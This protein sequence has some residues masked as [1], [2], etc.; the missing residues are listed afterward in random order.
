MEMKIDINYFVS[1]KICSKNNFY[2]SIGL[3]QI[4]NLEPLNNV[5]IRQLSH[6]HESRS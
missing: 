1:F 6:S 5:V 3:L 4:L 2:T